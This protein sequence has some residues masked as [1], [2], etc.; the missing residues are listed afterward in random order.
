M[1]DRVETDDALLSLL[2]TARAG[3]ARA[4]AAFLQGITPLIRT[5]IGGSIPVSQRDD[6][7]QEILLSVHRALP[8]YDT[9]RPLRPWL[10]AIIAYRKTDALR[11]LY[12]SKTEQPADI[13]AD[14]AHHLASN[15]ATTAGELKDIQAAL[16]Q[17][18]G[19]QRQVIELTRLRGLSVEE[20]AQAMGVTTT[21][22]KVSAHRATTKLKALLGVK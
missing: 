12:K 5:A 21:D 17:L 15:P 6:V 1:V 2:R 9:N 22:V 16:N 4:Y 3:D 19:K 7:A 20:A 13:E 11:Q 18:G 10:N 14:H 8:T